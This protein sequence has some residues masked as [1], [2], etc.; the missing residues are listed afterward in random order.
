MHKD[1]IGEETITQPVDINIYL[2][3]ATYGVLVVSQF[4]HD[5]QTL[6]QVYKISAQAAQALAYYTGVDGYIGLQGVA[7][8]LS[9]NNTL[10]LQKGDYIAGTNSEGAPVNTYPLCK[11][12]QNQTGQIDRYGNQIRYLSRDAGG[13]GYDYLN[14]LYPNDQS[15]NKGVAITGNAGCDTV[16]NSGQHHGKVLMTNTNTA[17]GSRPDSAS[18]IVVDDTGSSEKLFDI[19]ESDGIPMDISVISDYPDFYCLVTAQRDDGYWVNLYTEAGQKLIE[20]KT[21]DLIT[22]QTREEQRDT[23]IYSAI[24][25]EF[26]DYIYVINSLYPGVQVWEEGE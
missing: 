20:F 18:I 14:Y 15:Q 17:S 9:D 10:F 6:G 19:P 7:C 5:M 23:A 1:T 12:H 26:D 11:N 8:G 4:I 21:H 13:S 25:G 16:N 22:S 2:Y 24:K 3:D